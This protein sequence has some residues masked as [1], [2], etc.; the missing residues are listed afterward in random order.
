MFTSKN[1]NYNFAV[2][3]RSW[4]MNIV[5]DVVYEFHDYLLRDEDVDLGVPT[6]VAQYLKML[7][8]HFNVLFIHK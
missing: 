7:V 8:P 6:F 2:I 5:F 3:E 1:K 4:Y